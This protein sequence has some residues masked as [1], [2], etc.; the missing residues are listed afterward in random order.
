M[1]VMPSNNPLLAA[2]YIL[3]NSRAFKYSTAVFSLANMV[4]LMSYYHRQSSYMEETLGSSLFL[5]QITSI[6]PMWCY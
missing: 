3:I 2:V 1:K 5:M 6:S 4:V